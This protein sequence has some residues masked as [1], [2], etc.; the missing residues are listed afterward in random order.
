MP[1]AKPQLMSNLPFA[2]LWYT[3]EAVLCF[4]ELPYFHV[5]FRF[6]IPMLDQKFTQIEEAA[7]AKQESLTS[8]NKKKKRSQT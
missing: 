6:F 5:F 7:H 1:I 2:G 8:S 3:V 4:A